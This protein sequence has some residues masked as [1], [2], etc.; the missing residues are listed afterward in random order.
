MSGSVR[1]APPSDLGTPS[2]KTRH[3][4]ARSFAACTQGLR[5]SI[6]SLVVVVAVTASAQDTVYPYGVPAEKPDMELSAAMERAYEQYIAPSTWDNELFTKFRHSP[7]E[8]LDYHDGDGTISRRDPSKIVKANGKYYVWYT[9]RSTPTPPGGAAGGTDV[10]PSTDWDLAEIWYATSTDGFTWTEQGVAVKRPPKPQAGWRSVSTPDV[11]VW[12]GKYYLFYQ[13]FLEMS[14]TR[15]DDCPVTASWADSPDG[16]WH[17][18]GNVVIPNGSKGQWDQ[19]SIHD[20]YPLV[21]KGKIY[22]YYK[23]EANGKPRPVRFTGL[24]IADNPLGPYTKHPLNPVLNSGHETGLFPFKEGIAAMVIR[25]GNEHNTIQYAPDG[26]NFQVAS[27]VSLMP[28][29]SGPYVPDA[30]DGNDNGRGI[31]WGL[32]HHTGAGTKD[33]KHSI[34]YRFDCDLSLD[35][36]DEWMKEPEH[37]FPPEVYFHSQVNAGKRKQLIDAAE[38]DLAE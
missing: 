23:S 17:A 28:I 25:H 16:P 32:C 10:I 2:P 13:A 9:R 26:V 19:Y 38:K 27:S 36:H 1:P 37:W 18:V 34:L 14:G 5:W 11:L 8:G 33:K 21:Y 31:T 12:K 7:I 22:L 6:A 20:P 29:A 4:V 35:V 15:G 30:F 3:H 24:A